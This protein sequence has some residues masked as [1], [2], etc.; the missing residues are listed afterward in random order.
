MGAVIM[1]AIAAVVLIMQTAP[2]D[3]VV[4]LPGPDGKAGA[5]DVRTA[6]GE[7]RLDQAFAAVAV[8]R[9]GGIES[10]REDAASVRERYG[11]ALAAQPVRPT[12]FLLNFTMNFATGSDEIT[13]ESRPVLEQIIAEVS[14]RSAAEIVVI[15]HTDRV[16]SEAAN[17][18]LS[19][20]RAEAVRLALIA[21]GIEARIDVAGRGEREPLVP[22]AD[23]VAEPRNR[24]VEINVR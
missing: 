18:V 7:R 6:S 14:R 5:V 15:G 2:A 10:V 1:L 3:R 16:G 8:D 21:A 13:P 4:L 22:T 19:L 20:K 12:S 23:E 24:R 17:D 9:A 11:A